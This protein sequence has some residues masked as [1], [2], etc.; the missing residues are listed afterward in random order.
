MEELFNKLFSETQTENIDDL[1]EYYTELEE[2]NVN[3]YK[4]TKQM[5]DEID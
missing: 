5:I 3:Y 4:E 2:K 1:M